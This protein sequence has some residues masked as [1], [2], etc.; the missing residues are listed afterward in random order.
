MQKQ[1]SILIW[2]SSFYPVIGGVQTAAIEIGQFLQINNWDVTFITNHY[3]RELKQDESLKNMKIY[4]FIF[5]HSPLNYIK[6]Y[7][8]DLFAAWMFYKPIVFIKLFF[9]FIKIRPKLVHIHFPDNQVI[10]ALLLK[11]LFNFKLIVS[12]HGNDIEKLKSIS[13]KSFRF[14]IIE[15]LLL[16]SVIITGCSNYITKQVENIFPK[17]NLEKLMTLHNGV[18]KEFENPSLQ[19]E[20]DGCFFTAARNDPVKGI[21]LVFSLAETFKEKS[22]KI[23]GKG[24]EKVGDKSNIIV[25][26]PIDSS[27]IMKNMSQCSIVIVPSTSEAFGIVV[28]EALCCGSPVVATNVGGIPEVMKLAQSDLTQ[29]EISIFNVWVKLVEPTDKSLNEGIN[30]ILKNTNSIQDYL[31]IIPKIQKQFFW[32]TRLK[33]YFNYISAIS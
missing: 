19:K 10:E 16:E 9:L 12:F 32:D 24:F 11:K 17:V 3:P 15:Q 22:I 1:N 20:K 23:A 4:R 33:K 25:L 8:L 2:P 6:S 31:E 14:L 30:N 7:R 26:G 18:G 27:E 13:I 28:A 21:N 29:N 5:L